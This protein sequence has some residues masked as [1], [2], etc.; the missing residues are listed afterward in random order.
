MEVI[1]HIP[2]AYQW[3]CGDRLSLGTFSVSFAGG[4]DDWTA[5]EERTIIPCVFFRKLCVFVDSLISRLHPVT[6]YPRMH[7][8]LL[9]VIQGMYSF[10][11]VAFSQN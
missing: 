7:S 3:H 4:F 8:C 9:I 5:I 10:F 11:C 6:F 2:D 1:N